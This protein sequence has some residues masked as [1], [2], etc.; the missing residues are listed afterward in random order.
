M[1]GVTDLCGIELRD[2]PEDR[3][4]VQS[5]GDRTLRS[6]S[7]T[8]A[9]TVGRE[10]QEDML[11]KRR[12]NCQNWNWHSC[13]KYAL[14][15]LKKWK[16]LSKTGPII[17]HSVVPLMYKCLFLTVFTQMPI[18]SW[19]T[20]TRSCHPVTCAVVLTVTRQ[21]TVGT[22][23]T[24]RAFWGTKHTIDPVTIQ[25]QGENWRA[26]KH[27]IN[28]SVRSPFSQCSP[29]QPRPQVQF[30]LKESHNPPLLQLQR[31]TQ[32][33]PNQPGGQPEEENTHTSTRVKETK[34]FCKL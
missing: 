16:Y 17:V 30:P 31:W 5:Q 28:Q 20:Q 25:A 23:F 26:L 3:C 7:H 1:C 33:A 8:A 4:R 2:V 19:P 21:L 18:V 34:H 22:K 10:D 29:V 6:Y 32:S 24:C 27:K 11:R 13:K 14:K 15:Y 12:T 9:G